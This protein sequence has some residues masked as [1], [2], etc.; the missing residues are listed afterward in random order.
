MVLSRHLSLKS[1]MCCYVL[2][3]CLRGLSAGKSLVCHKILIL[4]LQLCPMLKI[5]YHFVCKVANCPKNRENCNDQNSN[6]SPSQFLFNAFLILFFKAHFIDIF[7]ILL[8]Q[9]IFH[10]LTLFTYFS[11][12]FEF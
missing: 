12:A 9:D 2:K 6:N 8:K 7:N 5:N 11:S 4:S 10:K 3:V 1:F